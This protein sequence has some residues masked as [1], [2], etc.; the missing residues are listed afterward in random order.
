MNFLKFTRTRRENA[1]STDDRNRECGY[2]TDPV[3]GI[4]TSLLPSALRGWGA[5]VPRGSF[6]S[7]NLKSTGYLEFKDSENTEVTGTLRATEAIE[8]LQRLKRGA[9]QF[10]DLLVAKPGAD[11]P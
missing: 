6:I 11:S 9:Q 3:D 2:M 4:L 5:G 8:D 7:A 1:D 10:G